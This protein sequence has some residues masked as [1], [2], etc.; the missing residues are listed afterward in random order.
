[1]EF[2]PRCLELAEYFLPTVVTNL[3]YRLAQHIQDA[4]EE[5]LQGESGVLENARND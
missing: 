5:W 4:I 1:M 3:Q 2:D